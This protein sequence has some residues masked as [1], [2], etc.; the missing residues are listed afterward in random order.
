M[1]VFS[2]KP[3]ASQQGRDQGPRAA[4]NSLLFRVLILSNTPFPSSATWKIRLVPDVPNKVASGESLA[5]TVS[6]EGR[7]PTAAP[8][9]APRAAPAW[10]PQCNHGMHSGPAVQSHVSRPLTRV[11]MRCVPEASL[12]LKALRCD[13]QSL[14]FPLSKLTVLPQSCS[15]GQGRLGWT[16]G[17]A[18]RV[19]KPGQK[20]SVRR[21]VTL[22]AAH[23]QTACEA[24]T[25]EAP[26]DILVYIPLGVSRT[27]TLSTLSP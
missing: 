21:T 12:P 9:P 16:S 17:G 8:T 5:F 6:A 11:P 10:G 22:P 4:P 7:S 26:V 2:L 25:Q 14:S 15:A 18:C 19:R 23:A 13:S 20:E 1:A 27:R 24:H 3:R